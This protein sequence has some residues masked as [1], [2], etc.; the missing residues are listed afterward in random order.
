MTRTLSLLASLLLCLDHVTAQSLSGKGREVHPK[1]DTYTCTKRGGCKKQTSYIVLDSAMH[2]IYQKD[3]PSLGC[4]DWGAAPNKTVCPDAKTC[5]KNCV[6]DQISDY[7]AY[8]VKTKGS[9]LY[10]DMLRDDLSTISPR[11]YLMDSDQHKYDMI[12]LTGNEFTF[13]VD[14]SKLPCGMNGALYLSE[15]NKYGGKNSLN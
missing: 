4:G 1:L 9:S 12:K 3:N 8:G 13:D 10:M 6:I 7:S 11:A 14:V 5:N 2:P 15:M